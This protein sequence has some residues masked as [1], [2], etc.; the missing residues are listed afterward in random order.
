MRVE[1]IECHQC[2]APLHV[3]PGMELVRCE[4]CGFQSRI[5]DDAAP[6]SQST[7]AG[8]TLAETLALQITEDLGVGIVAAGEVLPLVRTVVLATSRKSQE[9]FTFVVRSGNAERPVDNALVA[10]LQLMLKTLRPHRSTEAAGMT[11]RIDVDGALSITVKET[12]ADN[13]IEK[14]GFRVPV[15]STAG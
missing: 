2:G 11:V 1:T 12:G 4:Y 13:R 15:R 9:S 3:D 7:T 8:P 10:E 14:D 5:V 6:A